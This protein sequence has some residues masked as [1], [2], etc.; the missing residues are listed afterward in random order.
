M[1]VKIITAYDRSDFILASIHNLKSIL[2]EE[3]IVVSLVILIFLWHPPSALI[4]IITIPVTVLVA[5]IPLRMMGVSLN[6]MSLGGIAIAIGAVVDAAIV[7]VEQTHKRLEEWQ[8]GDGTEPYHA[9]VVRAIKEVGGASFFALLVIAV[10]FLPVL[11]LDCPRACIS[12]PTARWSAGHDIEY[13]R[14]HLPH[15]IGKC[16]LGFRPSSPTSAPA[17]GPGAMPVGSVTPTN[18]TP[19]FSNAPARCTRGWPRR[20]GRT[21]AGGRCGGATGAAGGRIDGLARCRARIVTIWNI[22]QKRLCGAPI[23]PDLV[24]PWTP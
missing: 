2:I 10:S 21:L 16:C 12:R 4:P 9:V 17:T 11:A 22:G 13:R 7:V 3:L 24:T 8:R 14:L 1:G 6:I 18:A 23:C 20:V 15:R 5:F 19:D